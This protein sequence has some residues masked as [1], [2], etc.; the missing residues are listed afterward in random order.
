[1]IYVLSIGPGKLIKIGYTGK[2]VEERI[3]QLQ[4]GCPFPIT[5]LFTVD[6]NI[7]QEKEIHKSLK[8][9]LNRWKVPQS[10]EW[11]PG[12][13]HIVKEFLVN[14]AYG[15]EVG[16]AFLDE[17]AIGKIYRRCT[18]KQGL[19]RKQKQ[20]LTDARREQRTLFYE[21]RTEYRKNKRLLHAPLP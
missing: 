21:L 11:Y 9:A 1:M 14:L 8:K 7:Y 5:P 6:G 18:T 20:S 15:C 4:T 16:L 17:D 3:A 12:K 10:G 19:T 13:N 2:S